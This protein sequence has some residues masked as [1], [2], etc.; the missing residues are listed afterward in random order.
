[1]NL[2]PTKIACTP[3]TPTGQRDWR[4]IDLSA[5]S[6]LCGVFMALSSGL[7][8][9]SHCFL[10]VEEHTAYSLALSFSNLSSLKGKKETKKNTQVRPSSMY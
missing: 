4:K 7:L 3:S 9:Q 1:M 10:C 8:V 2:K 6:C 5:I